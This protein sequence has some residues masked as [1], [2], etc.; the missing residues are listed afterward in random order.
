MQKCEDY[1]EYGSF[2]NIKA[3]DIFNHLKYTASSCGLPASTVKLSRPPRNACESAADN[4]TS[5]SRYRAPECM[6]ECVCVC[7]CDARIC[8]C[9]DALMALLVSVS[10]LCKHVCVYSVGACMCMRL[11]WSGSMVFQVVLISDP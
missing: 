7:M 4:L 10:R 11:C 1:R 6:C 8:T 9:E 2:S 5:I 3:M